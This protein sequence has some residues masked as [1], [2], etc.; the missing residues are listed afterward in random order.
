MSADETQF[1]I[2]DTLERK[3]SRRDFI[4]TSAL[5]KDGWPLPAP[6]RCDTL[7]V[8]TALVVR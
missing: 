5:S 3:A 1:T 8:V 4:K 6:I 2:S 7:N